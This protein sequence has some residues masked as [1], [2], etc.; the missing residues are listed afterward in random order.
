[1]IKLTPRERNIFIVVVGVIALWGLDV[2]AIAP[3]LTARSELQS[4]TMA[5][6]ESL[7]QATHLFAVERID[8]RKWE[9]MMR[10]GLKTDASAAESQMLH[11]IGDWSRDAGLTLTGNKPDRA[12][13]A[14]PFQKITFH[15]TTTGNLAAVNRFLWDA[16]TAMIPTRIEDL[17][18]AS[19]KEGTDDLSLSI[20]ISTLCIV[21]PATAPTRREVQ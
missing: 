6:T 12:E 21:P 9:Q 7:Q 10:Y 11:A 20:A 17:T 19:R 18:I 3:L 13:A 16:E 1:M 8:R 15:V 2:V 5:A 14:K 4:Q